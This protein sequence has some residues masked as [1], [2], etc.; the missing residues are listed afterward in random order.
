MVTSQFM[1]S[2]FKFSL[3]VGASSYIVPSVINAS[4]VVTRVK[5]EEFLMAV[6]SFD[7][8]FYTHKHMPS[9][10]LTTVFV[11]IIYILNTRC[12]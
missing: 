3:P 1:L 7:I 11:T 12:C 2:V 5:K 6:N 8:G 10:L 9:I 4:S